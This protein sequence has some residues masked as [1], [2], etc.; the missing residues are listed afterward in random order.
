M[1]NPQRTFWPTQYFALSVS[2]FLFCNHLTFFPSFFSILKI[3]KVMIYLY[4]GKMEGN[5]WIFSQWQLPQSSD[6]TN[7]TVLHGLSISFCLVHLSP[8]C[9]VYSSASMM[10]F[11]SNSHSQVLLPLVVTP[12][13]SRSPCHPTMSWNALAFQGQASLSRETGVDLEPKLLQN[14]QNEVGEC[15][16]VPRVSFWLW[17]CAE[18]FSWEE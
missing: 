14:L 13:P 5:S 7:C 4:M 18:V 11:L 8:P 6:K 3:S 15:N 9:T 2:F 16:L 12:V 1:G 17:K 10:P